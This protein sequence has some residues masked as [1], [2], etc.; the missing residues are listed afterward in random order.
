ML[1]K[2]DFWLARLFAIVSERFFPH[3]FPVNMSQSIGEENE[4]IVITGISGAFPKCDNVSELAEK[5][6]EKG[7]LI[8]G[9]K[10]IGNSFHTKGNLSKENTNAVFVRRS[11][12][13]QFQRW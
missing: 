6:F 8:T 11:A 4:K 9:K 3:F 10:K 12:G 13:N 5:L 7:D 2:R 1:K